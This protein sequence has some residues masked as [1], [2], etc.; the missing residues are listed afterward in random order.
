MP[1]DRD[2]NKCVRCGKWFKAPFW[3]VETCPQCLDAEYDA[4]NGVP[5]NA[6]LLKRHDDLVKSV[7]RKQ[8]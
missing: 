1:I 8:R 4:L 2:D 7:Q 5:S 3:K 6:E